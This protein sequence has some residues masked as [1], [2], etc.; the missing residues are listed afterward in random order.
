[1][2]KVANGRKKA[3]RPG[4]TCRVFGACP[5]PADAGY[6]RNPASTA[7]VEYVRL[8]ACQAHKRELDELIA[9]QPAS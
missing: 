9:H 1:M 6:V 7:D 3:R 4:R 8:L 5:N 2:A